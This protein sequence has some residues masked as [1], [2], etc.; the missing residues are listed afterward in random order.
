[1]IRV[2]LSMRI[3]NAAGY[4]E[5]RDSISHD[6]VLLCEAWGGDDIGHN[7]ERDGTETKLLDH[8]LGTGL[9]VLGVCRGMQL[10]N[11]RFGGRSASVDGHAAVH[12]DVD[13]KAPLTDF[14]GSK[15]EVNS[16]H[17]L[18]IAKNGL[19]AGLSAVAADIDG[20]VEALVHVAHAAVGV[21]WHPERGHLTVG[22]RKLIETLS[23]SG[24][25][26]R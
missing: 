18:C 12:H 17:D 1:M 19:G 16:Y 26:W 6:W 25:F 22:D 4:D 5:P 21:M 2:A 14:Y 11:D 7:P 8:A 15:T 10:I 24:A 13:V 20:H 9:P 3:T 23:T